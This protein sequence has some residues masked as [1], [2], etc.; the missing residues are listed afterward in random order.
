MRYGLMEH[1]ACRAKMATGIGKLI[2]AVGH[3]YAHVGDPVVVLDLS[4]GHVV[5][6]QELKVLFF[7]GVGQ[8]RHDDHARHFAPGAGAHGAQDPMHTGPHVGRIEP[9]G[10][11]GRGLRRTARNSG[12]LVC[13]FE[14]AEWLVT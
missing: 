9:P 4:E 8:L 11:R 3:D 13:G 12:I 6:E 1:I 5:F 2:R 10:G 14:Y 7:L